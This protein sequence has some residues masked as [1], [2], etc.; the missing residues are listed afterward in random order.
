MKKIFFLILFVFYI[1]PPG[2][3]YAVT[4]QE[5]LQ[6][7]DQIRA[8]AN[9]FTF[10]LKV[11]VNKNDQDSKAE[12]LV[13]V[14][15]AQ[16]SLVI[17]KSP[18]SNKGRVLL[19]IENNMWI[20]IPG[21]R[22]PLRISPQQQILGRVSNADAARVVFSLDYS[23]DSV[24]ED[25]LDGQKVLKM[26]LMAKTTGAAYK[27]IILWVKNETYQPIKAEFFALSGKLLKTAYYKKYQEILGQKRPTMLEI[28]DGIKESEVSI[29][30]YSDLKIE[31]TPDA[32][33][34]KTFM[35]RVE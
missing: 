32:Y 31:D 9:T 13:R 17:Y 10:H 26:S 15:D 24:T 2:I 30:E 28:H 5:I 1:S 14:K 33:Y 22:N 6:M 4:P 16:K 23:A 21:T 29:M 35:D 11:T 18:P 8:P 12:F 20:Y 7:V 19:L 25:V 34:Q 3:S 27:N